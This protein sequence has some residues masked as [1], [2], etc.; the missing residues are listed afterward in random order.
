M[1]KVTNIARNTSYLTIALVIQKIVSFTYFALLA[2]NLGPTD[3]GKYYFAIS[4]TTIFAIFIDFGL[5]NVLTREIAKRQE[6]A[7][8]LLSNILAIKIPLAIISL[9]AVSLAI[10]ILPYP[11]LT[12]HLVYLSSICMILDSFTTSF[13]GAV[14]GFHNLKYESI[15]SVIY[16]LIVMIFGLSALYAGWSLT[17]VM[18][19][20]VL[21]SIYNFSFSFYIIKKKLRIN[22]SPKIDKILLKKIIIISIPFGIYA[23]FQRFYT[24]FD[25][26]LL[27]IFA[28]DIFVGYY[29][30]PFKIIL[31]LQ[32]LPMAFTASLY[33]AMSHYWQYNREQLIITFERALKY[34]I[35]ISIPISIGVFA[36]ADKIVLVFQSGYAGAVWP[37]RIVI[38]AVLFN[39]ID[40]PAGSL[41]NA[42]DQQKRNTINM[43]IVVVTSII[44]N[45]ILI[46]KMQAVGAG[47]TLLITNVLKVSLDL[48][49][50]SKIIKYR[51][52]KVLSVFYK[53]AISVILMAIFV[54]SLKA[55]LNIILIIIF[56]GIIYFGFMFLFKAFKK[57]DIASI[58][59]SFIRKN[60]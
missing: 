40:F 41:L 15:S 46:P 29:Q 2:R 53:S 52:R 22:I 13:F 51:P 56:S 28:G 54:L 39:F 1:E 49:F 21:A 59:N 16:Q 38:L 11:P 32:F 31:A 12:R 20:L 17:A 60:I 3:L 5:T 14:R 18:S 7:G 55:R 58:W 8:K 6:G 10:N 37:L 50:G 35:I 34:L 45:F 33:P 57:E 9:L 42:C 43:G 36:L 24:Y 47:I 26:V 23:I 4:F 30:V 19:A 48:Y 25:T 44:F 27:S